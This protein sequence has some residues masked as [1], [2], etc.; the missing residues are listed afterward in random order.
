MQDIY[1]PVVPAIGPVVVPVNQRAAEFRVTDSQLWQWLMAMLDEIDYGVMLLDADGQVLHVNR[2]AWSEL[3]G[4]HPLQLVGSNLRARR[5]RDVVP[6]QAAVE[7]AVDRG[8][9]RLLVLG[10]AGAQIS[11]SVVPLGDAQEQTWPIAM[12]ML[13]KRRLSGE[14]AVQAFARSHGLT[15]GETRV[16]QALCNGIP[17]STAAAQHGVALSTVRSQIGSI[18][19]KT[20][21]ASIR[22]LVRTVAALPPFMGVLRCNEA[23]NRAAAGVGALAA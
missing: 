13:G 12:V 18:R 4:D 7:A 10:E 20:A 21:T 22:D 1:L 19:A 23:A 14:L 9:R 6:L 8:L 3:D 17:P 16:L 15:A 11:V 5:A 2:A